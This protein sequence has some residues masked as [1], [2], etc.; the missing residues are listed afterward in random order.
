[1]SQSK[2]LFKI[3]TITVLFSMLLAGCASTS[4]SAEPVA[5]QSPAEDSQAFF[6]NLTSMQAAYNFSAIAAIDLSEAAGATLA[7]SGAVWQ[8]ADGDVQVVD[9]LTLKN[10]EGFFMEFSYS[11]PLTEADSIFYFALEPVADGEPVLQ[12]FISLDGLMLLE[13][14][15]PAGNADFQSAL[16]WQAG[17]RYA[18]FIYMTEAGGFEVRM[19]DAVQPEKVA[20]LT[21]D[22]DLFSGD[23]VQL[24]LKLAGEQTLT[25]HSLWKFVYSGDTGAQPQ[26]SQD[27]EE[28]TLDELGGYPVISA[29]AVDALTCENESVGEDGTFFFD[30]ITNKHCDLALKMGEALAFDFVLA[31]PA[32]DWSR[33]AIIMLDANLEESDMPVKNLGI[34]LANH[35]AVLKM[36]YEEIVSIDYRDGFELEGG[37][38][39]S[40]LIIMNE[41]NGF[42]IQIW[43]VDDPDMRMNVVLDNDNV[44]PDWLP[45]EGEGWV[46]GMWQPEE[47]QITMSNMVHYSLG[48]AVQD[49]AE[50]LDAEES[51]TSAAQEYQSGSQGAEWAATGNIPNLGDFY[52][53]DLVPYQDIECGDDLLY[54]DGFLNFPVMAEDFTHQCQTELSEGSGLIFELDYSEEK[55]DQL[56]THLLDLAFAF[57]EGNEQK[58]IRFMPTSNSL[59]LKSNDTFIDEYPMNGE[60]DWEPGKR[61][62]IVFISSY[63]KYF[64]VWPSDNPQQSIQVIVDEKD[65]INAFGADD[66]AQNWQIRMWVAA[67]LDVNMYNVFRFTPQ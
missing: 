37:I 15:L 14:G 31:N 40:A 30:A 66:P 63:N 61:Y 48:D 11:Q 38:T 4:Q 8:A 46:F 55:A 20:L 36:D 41:R 44:T 5:A 39:Y 23:T 49:A 33:V 64:Y 57:G 28:I 25:I 35:K 52:I 13:D 9:G 60:I 2:N 1:M 12:P 56:D 65:K 21:A 27:I 29:A 7:E 19:W 59:I 43:P 18:M 22:Q 51:S 62:T 54:E 3:L 50:D 17:S 47:Q 6:T 24:G 34:T 16:D 26:Q 53:P 32:N 45:V 42:D 67:G 58:I 10:K